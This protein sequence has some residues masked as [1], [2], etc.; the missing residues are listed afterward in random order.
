MRRRWP[1]L[2]VLHATA[3]GMARGDKIACDG[4]ADSADELRRRAAILY[5]NGDYATADVCVSA[6]LIRMTSDL[7]ILAT[8]AKALR[9]FRDMRKAYPDSLPASQTGCM[10]DAKGN[11]V[12]LP[13]LTQPLKEVNVPETAAQCSSEQT[14]LALL[15]RNGGIP[16]L[17]Q[18]ASDVS[19]DAA[20]TDF[21]AGIS[22]YD[23]FIVHAAQRHWW[24]AATRAVDELRKHN[25][26]PSSE[27]RRAV[28][29]LRDGASSLLALM[30]QTKMD[31]ATI[32]CAIMCECKP[33]GRIH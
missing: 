9:Q 27:T 25:S 7:E 17:P 8:Q 29:E 11:T 20:T 21:A 6:A 5:E 12:C 3:T 23:E 13:E 15:D 18:A 28:T 32:N 10:T 30:R 24:T 22:F 2:V 31:E 19:T 26:P 1:L 33:L 16:T 14:A 4:Y